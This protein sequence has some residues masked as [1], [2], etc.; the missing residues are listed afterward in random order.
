MALSLDS[1][2]QRILSV[3]SENLKRPQP[4]VVAST[5]IADALQMELSETRRVLKVLHEDGA[6]ISDLDGYYSL[7]TP[8]GLYWLQQKSCCRIE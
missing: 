7:I 1:S 3:L 2:K 4:D 6:V 5:S 8:E